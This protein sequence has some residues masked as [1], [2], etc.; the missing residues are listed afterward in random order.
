MKKTKR[1]RSDVIYITGGACIRPNYVTCTTYNR[2]VSRSNLARHRRICAA[3]AGIA[4]RSDGGGGRG[5]GVNGAPMEGN[6]LTPRVYQPETG[7]T[8][9]AMRTA[10]LEVGPSSEEVKCPEVKVK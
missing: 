7:Q 4:G 2:E 6:I 9:E 10:D 8:Q 1:R 3:R 5:E